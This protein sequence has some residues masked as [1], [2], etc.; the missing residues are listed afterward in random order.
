[1]Q[2]I[3]TSAKIMNGA[4]WP[5]TTFNVINI[6]KENFVGTAWLPPVVEMHQ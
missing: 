4:I 6:D 2:P 3:P 5:A 1:M